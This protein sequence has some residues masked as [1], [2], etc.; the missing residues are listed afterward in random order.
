MKVN[1]LHESM[2]RKGIMLGVLVANISNYRPPVDNKLALVVP[3]LNPIK[4]HVY[5]LR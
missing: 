3:V 5:C 2:V 4:T 1:W